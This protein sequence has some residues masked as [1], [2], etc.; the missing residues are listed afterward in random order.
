M[1]FTQLWPTPLLENNQPEYSYH[2]YA[3]TD[4]YRT[5][6]RFGSNEDYRALSREAR[7]HGL[8]LIMDV[9]LNHV[10]SRH[11]WMADPPA[12]DWF[13]RTAATSK[14]TIAAPPCRTRTPRRRTGRCSSRAWFSRA[15]PDLNQRNPHLAR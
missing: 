9:V 13:N 2:G 15:M 10:G 5:D 3:I 7:G 14:P 4:L 6:P 1:G 12:A 11:W 8:G